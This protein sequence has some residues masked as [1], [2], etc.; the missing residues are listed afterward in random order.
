MPTV[1]SQDTANQS[2]SSTY[3]ERVYGRYVSAF[4]GQPNQDEMMLAIGKRMRV[5]DHWLG[6][7]LKKHNISDVLEIACGQGDILYWVQQRGVENAH[8]CD[9]S[10]EQVAVARTLGVAAE[11]APFQDYLPRHLDSCDLI[12]AVDIIEHLTR[13]EAFEL[14]DLCRAAL[15]PEGV[16]VL[17]TPNG[18]AY[19]PGPVQF[20]D[21]THETI[22]SPTS[23]SVAL[24]LSDFT[25]ITVSEMPPPPTSWKSHVRGWLWQLMRLWPLFVDLIE[26]GG[27]STKVLTRVMSVQANRPGES[28]CVFADE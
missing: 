1:V 11:V 21:L 8:G 6:P 14:L 19:R 28:L 9:V 2:C 20:G 17:T 10:P 15:R 3:R 24:R 27:C 4:K 25:G 18:A 5:L 26:T 22:F 13:D 23:I 12:I 7:L 16:L